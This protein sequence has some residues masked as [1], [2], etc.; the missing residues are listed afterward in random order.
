M[1]SGLKC[2]KRDW[3]H[4]NSAFTV[5]QN[6]K[7]CVGGTM[8]FKADLGNQST[9]WQNKSWTQQVQWQQNLWEWTVWCN[10]HF[11]HHC[12]LG[13][14]GH[15]VDKNVV[16]QCKSTILLAKNDKAS[17]GKCS[18]VLNMWCFYHWSDCMEWCHNW[19]LSNRWN[20]VR[21]HVQRSPQMKFN[22]FWKEIMGM[23]EQWCHMN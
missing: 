20:D 8:G 9:F 5:H 4:E 15:N 18:R 13:Q 17:S 10:S 16:T 3:Q 1:K 2:G 14:Q 12:F 23:E 19:V 7:G 11:G 21:L 22:K 6:F